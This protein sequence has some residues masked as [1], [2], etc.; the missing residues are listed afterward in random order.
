MRSSSSAWNPSSDRKELTTFGIIWS[1]L[2]LVCTYLFFILAS[3]A[4][5]LFIKCML[6]Y[7]K[8]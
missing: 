4:L 5:V 3:V 6:K 2:A 1:Y 8:Q 7:L